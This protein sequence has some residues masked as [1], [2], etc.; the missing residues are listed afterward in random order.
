MASNGMPAIAFPPNQNAYGTDL[1][2]VDQA[3][4]MLTGT[5]I[6]LVFVLLVWV[7]FYKILFMSKGAHIPWWGF[8]VLLIVLVTIAVFFGIAGVVMSSIQMSYSLQMSEK[9]K[10]KHPHKPKH[11]H[12]KS[13]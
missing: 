7:F 6:Y 2:T 8:G 9:Y 13:Y 4:W 3:A 11:I 12:R 10:H 1:I 5:V